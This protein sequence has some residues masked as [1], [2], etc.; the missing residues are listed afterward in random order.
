MEGTRI[1]LL[2]VKDANKSLLTFA[3]AAAALSAFDWKVHFPRP[4]RTILPFACNNVI[5][6]STESG[7]RKSYGGLLRR[8]I[9]RTSKVV[10]GVA[11]GNGVKIGAEDL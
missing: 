10:S 8:G 2:L 7:K 3:P 6:I 5:R 4:T 9:I 1:S 11:T